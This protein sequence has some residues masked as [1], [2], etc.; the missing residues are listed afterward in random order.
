[1][2]ITVRSDG[3]EG[4]REARIGA[5]AKLGRREPVRPRGDHHL[6]QSSGHAGVFD[7]ERIRL[8]ET[9]RRQA[10]SISALAAELNR[11]PRACAAMCSGWKPPGTSPP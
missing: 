9:A 6:R 4:Y 11:D 1:M 10:F 7:A 8:C 2:K 5:A 3:F